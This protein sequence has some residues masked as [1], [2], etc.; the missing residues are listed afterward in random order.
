MSCGRLDASTLPATWKLRT[1]LGSS[2]TAIDEF[3]PSPT[4]RYFGCVVYVGRKRP[5]AMSPSG[6]FGTVAASTSATTS[7]APTAASVPCRPR[8]RRLVA[9][10]ASPASR[11]CSR[12]RIDANTTIAET[13]AIAISSRSAC[14]V[15]RCGIDDDAEQ[16]RT[17]DR[18]DRV[19]R[20]HASD[21][22]SRVLPGSDHRGDR[23]RE[24]RAPQERGR[25][26]GDERSQTDRP[27]T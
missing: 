26:H 8:H 15:P 2:D 18:A 19:R 25:E 9:R 22:S 13:I 7:P 24:A 23:E 6:T 11:R 14:C 27:G 16:H 21:E 10:R 12:R 4:Y 17:D 20:V 3:I 1:P 5:Y